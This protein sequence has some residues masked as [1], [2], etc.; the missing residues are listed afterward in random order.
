MILLLWVFVVKQRLRI[1]A[2]L[3]L[4]LF[5]FSNII[6]LTIWE[7]GLNQYLVV[8]LVYQVVSV[9]TALKQEKVTVIG[10][11]LSQNQKLFK[12]I[13]KMRLAHFTKRI[14]YCSVKIVSCQ[15]LCLET[16]LTEK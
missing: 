10:Y 8:L 6:S 14:Y 7:K 1:N 16:S 3:G 13:H 4:Q 15:R 2:I 9:C 11:R 5:K 12:N